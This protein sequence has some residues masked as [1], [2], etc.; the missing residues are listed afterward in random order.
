M[1]CSFLLAYQLLITRTTRP[2]RLLKPGYGL[3]RSRTTPDQI[4]R[5]PGTDVASEVGHHPTGQ[6]GRSGEESRRRH[7]DQRCEFGWQR[8]YTPSLEE[9]NEFGLLLAWEFE[10]LLARLMRTA[11]AD[12]VSP[13][14]ELEP[15]GLGPEE[16][17]AGRF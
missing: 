15:L 8:W 4:G 7:P 12:S 10:E 9:G 16:D 11:I 14:P 6:E 5:T 1:A 13:Y 2:P 3:G 17:L